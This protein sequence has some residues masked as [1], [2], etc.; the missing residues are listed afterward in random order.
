MPVKSDDSPVRLS[1]PDHIFRYRGFEVNQSE[2]VF[3]IGTDAIL[4]G[5]WTALTAESP[6]SI[7]DVGTGTGIIA[8]I[9]AQEFP[10]AEIK[11]I[12]RNIHSVD[13]AKMNIGNMGGSGNTV[14]E[15]ADIFVKGPDEYSLVVCNPPFFHEQSFL[16][17]RHA[18]EGK[19]T[20]LSIPEWAK[21]LRDIVSEK[22]FIYLICPFELAF[23]W[24]RAF[25]EEHLYCARRM[26]VFS[27]EKDSKPIRTMICMNERLVKPELTRLHL[28]DEYGNTSE[29]YRR[30]T[31]YDPIK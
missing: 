21:A 23:E 5:E 12:D 24:I 4:L 10:H 20:E 17:S 8:M 1:H 14:V 22:G 16:K 31:A 11:A 13:L 15:Y 3:K 7:I 25:G 30:L 2:H 28:Y 9:L 29:P 6:S 26:D 18:S 27:R 19:N